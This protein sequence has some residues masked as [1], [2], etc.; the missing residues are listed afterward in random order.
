MNQE[1]EEQKFQR[2][3]FRRVALLSLAAAAVLIT[4]MIVLIPAAKAEPLFRADTGDSVITVHSEPC[5]VSAVGNLPKR[6]TW[7]EKGKK[8]EGCAGQHPQFPILIFYFSGDRSVV[9]VPAQL[10]QRVT[11]T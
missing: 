10:F 7:E 2:A 4:A 9:V 3:Y 11:G 5:A 6:A 1:Q 8:Y